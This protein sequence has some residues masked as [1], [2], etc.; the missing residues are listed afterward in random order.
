MRVRS[1]VVFALLCLFVAGFTSVAPSA[2]PTHPEGR[3]VNNV[4]LTGRPHGVTIAP[5]GTFCISLIDKSEIACGRLTDTRP[6][7][8]QYVPVGKTP[9]HVALDPAGRVAYTADQRGNTSSIVDVDSGEV[10]GTVELGNGGFNVVASRQRAYV[11]TAEGEL[12]VIDAATRRAIAKLKIG[13][14][15]ANGLALDTLGKRLYVS[16]LDAGTV[17][18]I[19]TATNM[20]TR[21]FRVGKGAQRI[22][23][24][25]TRKTLYVASAQRGAES[26]DLASGSVRAIPGVG[27]GTVGMA[28]SPD[29]ARLYITNPLSGSLIIV[30]AATRRVIKALAGLGT[31]RNVAFGL[32]G[33]MALVTNEDGSVIVIR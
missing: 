15:G 2:R 7:V 3:I 18:E 12:N 8:E 5:N 32:D 17:T 30:D 13:R 10:I 14:G 6:T 23:L 29:G 11:T 20:K 27:Q 33:A 25:P 1:R 21:T 28:V 22:A 26:I 4:P 19:N 31:P 24:S 16:S 9:A